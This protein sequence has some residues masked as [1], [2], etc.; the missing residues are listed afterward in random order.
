M[1]SLKYCLIFLLMSCSSSKVLVDYDD[2]TNFSEYKTYNF[3]ENTGESLNEF[4]KR[5]ILSAIDIEMQ[6]L[7]FEFADVPDFFID[8]K[9]KISKVQNNNTIGI[10]VGSGGRNGGFGISGGIPI[11][12]KKLNEEITI[13]F[14]TPKKE[15]LFWQGILNTKIKE[16]RTPEE[17]EIIYGEIIRKIL[18]EFPPKK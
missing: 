16:K 10:G 7:G 17:K 4:D 11:G 18:K 6:N 15:A 8:F 2:Q 12:G 9:S 5:R 14:V 13:D 1:K 3:F